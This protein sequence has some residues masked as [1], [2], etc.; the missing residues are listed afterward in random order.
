MTHLKEKHVSEEMR[1]LLL[2]MLA[3]QRVQPYRGWSI[4]ELN[5]AADKAR[6][7]LGLPSVCDLNPDI[8]AMQDAVKANFSTLREQTP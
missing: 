2:E 8:A 6:A 1:E 3:A 7:M 5:K 4:T